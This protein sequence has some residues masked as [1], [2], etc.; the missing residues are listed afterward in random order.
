MGQNLGENENIK[1]QLL[2]MTNFKVLKMQRVVQ[3]AFYF[4]KYDREDI[5]E[6]K[7]NKL[8]WKEAK[9][10]FNDEFLKKLMT[11]QPSGA[12]DEEYKRYWLLNFVERNLAGIEQEAVDAYNGALGRLF[13]WLQLALQI[14]KDDILR[15]KVQKRKEREERALKQTQSEEREAK[16]KADLEEAQTKFE[17]EHKDE[18]EAYEKYMSEDNAAKPDDYGEEEEEEHEEAKPKEKPERPVFN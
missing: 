14:R 18:I 3:T 5:C 17:E 6:V 15:R 10:K 7:T 16:C 9:K 13:R 4:L 12:K 8:F 2:S 11:Y 1:Q